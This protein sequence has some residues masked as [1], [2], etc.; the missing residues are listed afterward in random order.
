MPM[1]E[2]AKVVSVSNGE[3]EDVGVLAAAAGLIGT[4]N[5]AV[6]IAQKIISF[7]GKQYSERL[8]GEFTDQGYSSFKGSAKIMHGKG[9][10]YSNVPRFLELL[11]KS[12]GVPNQYKDEMQ[13]IGK[14]AQY[15]SRSDLTK[16]TIEFSAGSGGNCKVLQ[17]YI[18]TIEN[19]K[20]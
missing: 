12:R 17:F 2:C 18:Q 5:T 19:N 6:G 3:T 1:D 15:T 4:V 9:L 14:W 13:T 8:V 16:Q 7:F 10:P 11:G 20:S